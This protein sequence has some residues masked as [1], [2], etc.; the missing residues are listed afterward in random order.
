MCD[1][2]AAPDSEVAYVLGR[3]PGKWATAKTLLEWL[4]AKGLVST[5]HDALVVGAFLIEKGH[6]IPESR[7]GTIGVVVG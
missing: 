1:R 7:T 2:L 6:I 4:I 5:R 3:G